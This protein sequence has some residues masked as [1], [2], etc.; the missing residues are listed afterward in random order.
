VAV[1]AIAEAL[2]IVRQPNSEQ[3]DI[4]IASAHE[5]GAGPIG[6]LSNRGRPV[7]RG[8]G[9]LKSEPENVR[10]RAIAE[11]GVKADVAQSG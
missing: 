11:I 4:V 2:V 5:R 3:I 9:K 8:I 7:C 6:C 1:L 10:L